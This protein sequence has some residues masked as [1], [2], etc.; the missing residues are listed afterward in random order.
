MIAAKPGL[1]PGVANDLIPGHLIIIS[2]IFWTEQKGNYPSFLGLGP[3]ILTA[4]RTN[5]RFHPYKFS[6]LADMR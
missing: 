2:L 5:R 3:K 4:K 6:F 1:A